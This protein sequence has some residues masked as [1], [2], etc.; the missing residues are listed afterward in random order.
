MG[1][2]KAARMLGG[3]PLVAFAAEALGAVCGTV[4]VVCKPGS[5]IP[6]GGPWELWDDEPLTPRHPAAGIVHALDRARAQVLV[7][8]A[9]M[10]FVTAAE[11]RR[12]TKAM[13]GELQAVVAAADGELQPVFGVYPANA[14]GPLAVAAEHGEPLRRATEALDPIL[15]ELPVAA[16]RSIDTPA[17]LA[18]AN[19]VLGGR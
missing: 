8:A 5:A 12:L 14:A 19:R 9:D 10:P 15:V 7:C 4:A 17:E 6:A 2:D 18:A 11:C 1:G 3:R 13:N 16:L